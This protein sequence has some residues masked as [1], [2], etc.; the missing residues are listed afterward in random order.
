MEAWEQMERQQGGQRQK[1][2]IK[3]VNIFWSHKATVGAAEHEWSPDK[4]SLFLLRLCHV[5][6]WQCAMTSLIWIQRE[7]G[8]QLSHHQPFPAAAPGFSLEV[9][10]Q[11]LNFSDL[12]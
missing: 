3:G 7:G 11:I 9:S 10:I 8:Q 2:Q 12:T 4:A 1:I 6:S 5:S